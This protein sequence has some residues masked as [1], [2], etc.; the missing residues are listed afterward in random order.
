MGNYTAAGG[1]TVPRPDGVQSVDRA[2]AS[3]RSSPSGA[4]RASARS[5]RRS[6]CT[7]RPRSACS[8]RWR[9]AVWS[10]RRPSG[11]STGSASASCGWPAR[12]RAA[13]TSPSRAGRLRAAGRGDRR[14]RQHRRPA[15]ALRG[16]PLPG[17]RPGRRRRAQL[18]R[19]ADPAARHVQRQ[20]P[21][22]PPAREGARRGCSRRPGW[23]SSPRTPDREDEAGEEPRRGA[24][25]RLRGDAGGTRDRTAR[26]GRPD[27]VRRRRGHRRP[28]RLR[29]RLPVHRGRIHEL[30]PVLVHGAEEI[31]HR[32]GYAG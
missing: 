3:W 4:R 17:A 15:G 21:A 25:A 9:R 26:H 8:A 12:S 24:G 18:G 7:S 29:P 27:P 14:D 13:S 5:P 1:T 28:Q 30:A 19:P 32:M 20:D 16:Q 10:S 6:R 2:S 22:G 31:S 23:R 11:A